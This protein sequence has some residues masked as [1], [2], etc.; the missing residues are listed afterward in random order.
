MVN[1]ALI[2]EVNKLKI[3]CVHHRE[4]CEW[5]GEIETQSTHLESASG[6]GYVDVLCANEGQFRKC[7]GRMKR[8][9]FRTHTEN[10]CYYRPYVCEHCGFGDTYIAIAFGENPM[11][12]AAARSHYS[13][14]NEYPLA[15]PNECG[16][17][18][19]KRKAIVDHHK[20]CPL[21]P[22]QCSLT[23]CSERVSR[24]HI[25][26][27]KQNECNYRQFECVYCRHV[28]TYI[29]IR[30]HH[31]N[32]FPE[33]PLACPNECNAKEMKRKDLADHRAVCMLEPLHCS[34]N[35]GGC[36]E[37]IKR[38][39]MEQH[40]VNNT[41]K[42]MTLIFQSEQELACENRDLAQRNEKLSYGY[43]DLTQKNEELAREVRHLIKKN[44]E[45]DAVDKKMS[46]VVEELSRSNR[47]LVAAQKQ[48]A[49]SINSL[50]Y[51]DQQLFQV[52][53][54]LKSRIKQL[55]RRL[56][57]GHSWHSQYGPKYGH[58]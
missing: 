23:G 52:Y 6:C 15:C 28:D 21:E 27:H 41:Q 17:T 31:I 38:T 4:G 43:R 47:E 50:T 11:L 1:K 24:K 30:R 36:N 10:E 58:K 48:I 18:G 3:R 56:H 14:C 26:N 45:L 57:Q 34:F 5:V 39:D 32:V 13:M 44:E 12:S 40:M 35:D 37:K 22:V 2:R 42:H 7:G 33:Y 46:S 8:K 25:K 51:S 29:G 49:L 20:I 9:D 53:Q 16:V 54:G 55:E 19:I